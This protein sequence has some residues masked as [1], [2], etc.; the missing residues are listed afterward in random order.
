MLNKKRALILVLSVAL[1]FS[2]GV[3]AWASSARGIALGDD[4]VTITGPDA[5]YGNPAAVRAGEHS[6]ALE[7]VGVSAEFWNNLFKND[8][9]DEDEK[10]RLLDKAGDDGLLLGASFKAG[11]K[12]FIGPV[13]LFVDAR[14]DGLASLSPDIAELLLKGN[15]FNREYDFSGTEISG[16]SYGDIGANISLQAPSSWREVL[17]VDDL[18]LGMNYHYLVGVIS[19]IEGEG[20]IKFEPGNIDLDDGRLVVKYNEDDIATGS[21]FD[22]G[23]YADLN[24]R[25]SVGFSVMGLG[26]LTADSYT[27]QEYKYDEDEEE[28]NDGDEDGERIYEELSWSLPTIVRLGGEMDFSE[29]VD[30]LGGYTYTSYHSGHS[31]HKLS[32]ATEFTRLSFLPLRTGI[33]YST[34]QNNVAISS[35]LGLHLGPFKLDAGIADLTGLFYKSRGMRA[36]VGLGFEF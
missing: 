12:L 5:L 25:Y 4:F 14:Q 15:E 6:F 9:L 32:L 24:E 22:L 26:S 28:F 27:K 13:G 33:S 30:F 34:L 31:D 1:V 16:G 29:N 17:A 18:Y 35:G 7:L 20:G 11:P 36:G 3:T 21:A 23:A 19:E 8:Y 10:D 2:L